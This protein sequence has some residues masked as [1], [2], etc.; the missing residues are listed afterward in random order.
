MVTDTIN[1]EQSTNDIVAIPLADELRRNYASDFKHIAVVFPNF[2]H[3]IAVGDKKMSQ[4]GQWVQPDLPEMLSLQI[5]EGK[6]NALQDPTSVLLSQSLSQALFG[7]SDPL[8]KTLRL[9]N[10][11]EVK[12]GGIYKDLPLNSSFHDT[13][14][15]LS[16]D[17]ALTVMNWL[18]D[19]RTQWDNR[20]QRIYVQL[21]DNTDIDRVNEKIKNIISQHVKN[22]KEELQ[23]FPM[24]KWHLYGEFKNGKISGG[25]IQY[26]WM[27]GI[28][29]VFVLLLACIN[30]INLSTARSEKRAKEVGIRKTIGSTK[31]QLIKQFLSES[32]LVTALAMMLAIAIVWLAIPF[33][34]KLTGKNLSIPFS[35]P[36]FLILTMAFA[37]VT[38]LI[39]GSYPAFY[40]SA[41]EPIKVLKGRFRVGRYESLPRKALVIVQFTVSMALMI[42]TIV[43]Y[44][45]IQFAKNRPVG[46]SRSG[47]LSVTMNTPEIYSA[48]YN[49]LRSELMQTGTVT[50]MAKSS[51]SSTEAPANNTD[52]TWRGKN[53]GIVPVWG[54]VL[55]S[56][57]YGKTMDWKITEGRDFSR[58]FSTD[59]GSFILNDAAVKVMGLRNPVGESITSGGKSHLIIGVI[60]DMV[61]ESPYQPV[62]PTIFSLGFSDDFFNALTVRVN[63]RVSMKDALAKMEVVFKKYNPNGSFEYKFIDEEYAHKFSDEERIG[64]LATVFAILAIFISCLGLFG[65]STFV[66]EQRKKEIG[67]RKVLGASVL[68]LWQLLSKEFITLVLLSF[69]VSAPISYYFMH[70]WLQ[71]YQYR[72]AFPGW[73]FSLTILVALTITILT[74]SYQAIKGAIAN[75]VQSLRSE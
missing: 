32:L 58:N 22:S 72:T 42:G 69:L 1:G 15:F 45:Q 57:D 54:T 28:I 21:N 39:S 20:V 73:I 8:N 68:N 9:D 5:L 3:T 7:Y 56:H 74:V 67:I 47:L 27:F 13:K 18:K 46:Y 25:R 10:M 53:P 4:S 51:T 17:K 16:W 34:N 2:T 41:F 59:S 65:L 71:N 14:L 52:I 64:N 49:A 23:L 55:V 29:G 31:F 38:G 26:V 36:L 12:V 33:F 43:V 66:M 60:K 63:P 6:R 37:I 61:M 11:T 50:D 24:N 75:P 40:L 44:R 62:K 30:F 48:P 35:N 19:A 70:N